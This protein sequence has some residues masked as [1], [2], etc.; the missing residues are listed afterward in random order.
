VNKKRLPDYLKRAKKH[1]LKGLWYSAP[2]DAVLAGKR[3]PEQWVDSV[4]Q[5]HDL[6][7]QDRP[8][9]QQYLPKTRDFKV[10]RLKL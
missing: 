10:E 1:F 2:V 5:E 9:R 4:A 3:S 8:R 6:E 7:M